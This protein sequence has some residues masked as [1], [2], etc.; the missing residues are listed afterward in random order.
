MRRASASRL[1]CALLLLLAAL[2]RGAPAQEEVT[3]APSL[4]HQETSASVASPASLR[5]ESFEIVWRTIK[6]KHFDPTFGGVDWDA[7]REQYAPRV[8][9]ASTD[10][11]FYG[12]LQRMLGELHQSHFNIIPPEALINSADKEAHDGSIG[13][14]LRVINRQVV[15]TRVGPNTAAARAGLRPGFVL[16]EIDSTPV[17]EIFER[18]SRSRG[19]I[20]NADFYITRAALARLKGLPATEVRLQYLDEKDQP[21][22]VTLRREQPA[23][24]MS[25]RFGN[26]PPQRAEFEMKRLADGTGYIRFN[27]FVM[28]LMEKIRAAIRA[29]KDAPG[30]IIDL[31]GNPGG[32]GGMAWGTAGMLTG[33]EFSLGTM[34]MRTGHVNFVAFPQRNA[35]G[36]PVVILIDG[37]S[38]STTEIFAAGMQE[39]GRAIIVGERSA[40][41]ALPS[42]IQKLPTGALFQYAIADFRTPKG[43]LIEGRGVVPDVEIKLRRAALLEGRDIQLDAALEQIKRES[44]KPGAGSQSGFK[45]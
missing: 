32:I 30:L 37:L 7:V 40:G 11:E 31:R 19:L 13:C 38:A 43:T 2:W 14:D 35:Y 42:F 33:Q 45:R 23:G 27:V 34:R 17:D 22:E 20:L 39:A 36:G 4:A 28:P 41:A 10:Q 8:A 15:I 24:E 5:Q 29:L 9:K 44:Q 18:V 3:T 6:E 1:L 12:L 21:H 25:P 16:R 26:F